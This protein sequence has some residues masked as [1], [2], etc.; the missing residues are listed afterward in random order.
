MD[1]ATSYTERC[2]L[3]LWPGL[4]LSS[5]AVT[6]KTEHQYL[7][8]SSF[9]STAF[10]YGMARETVLAGYTDTYMAAM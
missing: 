8:P 2:P 7:V 9:E 4:H 1:T 3:N 6:K 10:C 5:G